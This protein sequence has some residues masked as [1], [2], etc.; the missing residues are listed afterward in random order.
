MGRRG[1]VG[2][3]VGRSTIPVKALVRRITVK[4]ETYGI[5]RLDRGCGSAKSK[6]G[7]ECRRIM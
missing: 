6:C 5:E 7:G 2:R 1:K 4:R 3:T